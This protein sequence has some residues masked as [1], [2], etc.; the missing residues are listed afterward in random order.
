MTDVSIGIDIGGTKVAGG[1]VDRSG[2]IKFK[3][4][5][6]TPKESHTAI[7]QCVTELVDTLT[8]IARK[9]ACLLVGIGIGSAG[10][11]DYRKGEILSG[12]SNIKDWNSIP[13]MNHLK[14][15]TDVPVWLDNDANTFAIAEHRLG[16]GKMYD[17]N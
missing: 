7:L 15:T 16:K 4:V 11:I 8:A 17:D 5:V 10:Q 1:L 3:K 9:E 13:L 14:K 2:E 12:T 6:A